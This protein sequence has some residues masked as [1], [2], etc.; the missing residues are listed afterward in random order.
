M[1]IAGRVVAFFVVFRGSAMGLRSE[2]MLPCRFPVEILHDDCSATAIARSG[3][4]IYSPQTKL[5]GKSNDHAKSLDR[6]RS[7]A[8][9]ALGRRS[10]V[11]QDL[12]WLRSCLRR[13]DKNMDTTS[14]AY[15][16]GGGIGSLAA[17]AFMVRDGDVP[18]RNIPILEAAP[19][20]GDPAQAARAFIGLFQGKNSGKRVVEL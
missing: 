19:V 9:D 4:V 20:T 16:V 3:P 18:S 14:K 5:S 10:I 2:F 17:A 1:P 13:F 15:L 6:I 12:I 7:R 11:R 8:A